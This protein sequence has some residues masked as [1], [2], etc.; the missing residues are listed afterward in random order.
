MGEDL[1]A[2]AHNERR[3]ALLIMENRSGAALA[4]A[5]PHLR[6][7][8][9]AWEKAGWSSR[10]AECLMDL[11]RLHAKRGHHGEAADAYIEASR[12]YESS[13]DLAQACDAAA[14]AGIALLEARQLDK[15]RRYTKRAVDI[16]SDLN[17][18]IRIAHAQLDHARVLIAR[19]EAQAAIQAATKALGIFTDYRQGTQRARCIEELAG[20]HALANEHDAA[21]ERYQEAVEI[22]LELGRA[23]EATETL[24]RWANME[25]ERGNHERAIEI[26][27]RCVSIAR[28]SSKD[29]LLAQSQRLLGMAHARRGSLDDAVDCY[30]SSLDLCRHVDDSEGV[31]RTLYLMGSVHA[32]AG[33]DATALE[34]FDE[35]LVQAERCG[36]LKIKE[37]ILAAVAKLH[38]RAGDH[39]QALA[40]MHKWIDVLADL[41][42][43]LERLHVLGTIAQV[44]EERGAYEEA[45]AHLRR[46]ISVCTQSCDEDERL[47][48]HHALA[49]LLAKLGQHIEAISHF[50]EAAE[51][52]VR[53]ASERH[54]AES[55]LARLRYQWGNSLLHLNRPREAIEQFA[56]SAAYYDSI[57]DQRARA[58]GLVGIGNAHSLL[59]DMAEA[60]KLF[61]EAAQLCEEQGDM[62]ATTIIRKA[63]SGM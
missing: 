39:D 16:A 45:E 61:D 33:D 13:K 3:L 4:G 22:N 29:A 57:G 43:R 40:V 5:V 19:G 18:H 59:E 41:G 54:E 20:A 10:K 21:A 52:Y 50:E 58:R 6:A 34:E 8:I 47:Y 12:I 30:Q 55:D 32:Q 28:R 49:V 27:E 17:D 23:F 63:T 14:G 42:D 53:R 2:K 24:S 56:A 44:H 51:G 62:R 9:E 11:G 35:A 48:A 46:L 60:K 26:L 15:A 38:R 1:A 25:S 37:R 31:A 7:A 36:I